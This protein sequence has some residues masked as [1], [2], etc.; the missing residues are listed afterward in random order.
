MKNMDCLL[1][2]G[3][4]FGMRLSLVFA[5][6]CSALLIFARM[7]LPLLGWGTSVGVDLVADAGSPLASRCLSW[8]RLR[9]WVRCPCIRGRIMSLFHN[10]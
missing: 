9:L 6:V 10:A 2:G 5:C 4:G 1:G 7:S 3:C 8:V